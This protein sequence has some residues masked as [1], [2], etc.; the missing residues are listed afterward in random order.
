MDPSKYQDL[1]KSEAIEI[2]Q[3][4]NNLLVKL[5]KNPSSVDILNE[6]FRMAHTL[7]G[8]AATMNYAEVV[9]LS[10]EMENVLDALRGNPSKVNQEICGVLFEAFDVLSRLVAQVGSSDPSS[11]SQADKLNDVI[12]QLSQI[13]AIAP[14]PLKPQDDV[15]AERRMVRINNDDRM[16]I[17]QAA[18]E[19]IGTYITKIVLNKDC[20]M[21]EARAFVILKVLKDAGKI[22]NEAYV[23]NQI[24]NAQFGRSFVVFFMTKSHIEDIKKEIQ[25]IQDVAFVDF[26]LMPSEPV[27][28][29]AGPSSSPDAASSAQT[30]RVSVEQLET[31]VNLVGEL[32]INKMQLETIAQLVANADFSNRLS[33]MHRL[34]SQL[35]R[36]VMAMR[37]FPMSTICDHFPRMVRDLAKDAGKQV[38]LEILGAD[39]GLDR[40]ILDEIKDPLVHILRNCVDHGIELPALRQQKGKNP[41]GL[42]KIQIRKDRGGVLIEV[43]DDGGGMDIQ[44]IKAKAVSMGLITDAE[45]LRLSDQEAVMLITAPGLSTAAVVTQVSGRG[46]GMDIVKKK[47]E[48]VGG[49]FAIETRPSMGSRFSISLPVTMTILKGLMVKVHH[50]IYAIPVVN[51]A[52]IIYGRREFI[53]TIDHKKVLVENNQSIPLVC[54]RDEFG[55]KGDDYFSPEE[56]SQKIPVV[57]VDVN[58]KTAG[59]LVDGL[60]KEQDMI[61]K[62]LDRNLI[63]VK[64]IG[65][66]TILGTGRVALIIDVPAL[67]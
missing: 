42:I 63:K 61:V 51:I 64:G 10:H 16:L 65:G 43:T 57:I 39:I 5:E 28:A 15:F 52:K 36:E 41:A 33:L 44:R 24:K 12:K 38:N 23:H 3:S 19:G 40:V 21:P 25:A 47:V 37:L 31:I 46:V 7:K 67:V 62:A 4:L 8:M 48:G 11:V 66:V 9:Q 17:A 59:L 49:C 50:Q 32:V 6:I 34:M 55:F 29:A 26:E 30:I 56:L 60:V 2:L 1:F 53:K 18:L 35:Q 45:A 27:K 14:D 20:A 58:H 22:L 54:L 13:P